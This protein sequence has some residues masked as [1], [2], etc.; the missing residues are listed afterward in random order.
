[1][2][3]SKKT[4]RDHIEIAREKLLKAILPHVEFDGWSRTS[5]D[6]AIDDSGVDAGL[7]AQAA[8]RGA[9]DLAAA[10]HR[11]GDQ[12]MLAAFNSTDI[13]DLRYS[14]K[15]ARMV[16]FRIEAV[17]D[18]EAVRRGMALFALPQNMGEGGQLIW[19]TVDHIWNAL[20]D[21]STDAN[22]YTKRGTLSAV[23]SSTILF[24]L[25]D[26]S[27][28]NADTWA[29]LARRIENV[30]QFEKT[31]AKIK[32]TPIG[33]GLAGFMDR[34]NKPTDDHKSDFPGYRGS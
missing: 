34:F 13:S 3:K 8:P 26:D 16:Q 24:W 18:K 22:W 15:V 17:Q 27:E 23:Y 12:L 1:M 30:M 7:A 9:I 4:E 20:G 33:R 11:Q 14:E 31:K 10:F 6:M 5:L 28:G 2:P 32:D 21:T 25:G 19:G 29:F